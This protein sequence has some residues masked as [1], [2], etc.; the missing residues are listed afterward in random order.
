MAQRYRVSSTYAVDLACGQMLAPGETTAKVDE[1]A[2]PDQRL[3]D[4]G[5]LVAL[6]SKPRKTKKEESE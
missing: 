3:I 2:L 6:P 4:E 5:I 1:D